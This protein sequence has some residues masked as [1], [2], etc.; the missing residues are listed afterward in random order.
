MKSLLPCLLF[1]LAALAGG[2]DKSH[3][4]G[5]RPDLSAT[6]DVMQDDVIR[7]Q[8]LYE[9]QVHEA[10]VP[11]SGGTVAFQ[12]AGTL[13]EIAIDCERPELTCPTELLTSELTLDNRA[14]DINDDGDEFV[15]S[16]AGEGQGACKL[17]R[18]SMATAE[19]ETRGS[20]TD[21]WTA[22]ALTGGANTVVL[23]PGCFGT[24]SA[25]PADAEIRLV[26]GFTAARR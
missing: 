16:F 18:G 22:T 17:L 6:W 8:V 13:S 1:A 5:V 19:V 14:G 9:G 4:L 2:C 21:H 23:S 3:A 15:L 25:L 10:R 11:A 12:D 20:P 7:V 24:L 26:S